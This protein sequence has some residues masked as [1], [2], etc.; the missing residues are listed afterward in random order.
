MNDHIDFPSLFSFLTRLSHF[1]QRVCKT[2]AVGKTDEF[3]LQCS[4]NWSKANKRRDKIE[5]LN[6]FCTRHRRDEILSADWDRKSSVSIFRKWISQRER[7][8]NSKLHG[9]RYTE[10]TVDVE[11][12]GGVS[13]GLLQQQ[14]WWCD[15]DEDNSSS[16]EKSEPSRETRATHPEGAEK[17]VK[18]GQ[19]DTERNY[20]KKN[21]SLI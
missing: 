4:D 11:H 12:W 3:M 5:L 21:K 15:D 16:C 14:W 10:Q 8:W 6:Q 17:E 9:S 18:K 7:I 20:S 2:K 13:G 1:N 19:S